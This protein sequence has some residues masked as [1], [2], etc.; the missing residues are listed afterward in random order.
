MKTR[1]VNGFDY[2]I[3]DKCGSVY[4]GDVV[5]KRHE[6][7]CYGVF[8]PEVF[9]VYGGLAISSTKAFRY[10]VTRVADDIKPVTGDAIVATSSP[11]DIYLLHNDEEVFTTATVRSS[12]VILKD[13]PKAT[14]AVQAELLRRL[15]VLAEKL[16]DIEGLVNRVSGSIWEI[17]N[18]NTLKEDNE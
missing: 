15:M 3:C 4:F 1:R 18:D 12:P 2:Y 13:L 6:N 17:K 9:T 8:K 16:T 14:A 11:D 10:G 7:S 5:C